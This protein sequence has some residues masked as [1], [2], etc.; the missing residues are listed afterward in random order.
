MC[1]HTFLSSDYNTLICRNCGLE[2]QSELAPSEGY[3]E[4]M[5]L[6][7]GYSRYNRMFA[8]L[9]KL[10]QPTMYGNPNSRVVYEVLKQHFD[11]GAQ[12][13]HWLS[14]LPNAHYYFSIHKPYT[15]PN[16]PCKSKVLK[17]LSDFSTLEHRFEC[18]KHSYKSFFSYNWLLRQLLKKF[19]LEIYLPFVKQIKCRKRVL[20][21]KTMYMF[22]MS[23]SNVEVKLDASQM[24]QIPLASPQDG[25]CL[26]HQ[27]LQFSLNRLIRS[28]RCNWELVT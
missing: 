10:F 21:Y 27:V 5:P 4:N 16:P 17:I 24:S 6:E 7:L 14:K 13:L 18:W 28:H 11:N 25:G 12:L 23:A 9:N 8:L 3:T 2:I 26:P 15:V 20:L 1:V 22:F 19:E